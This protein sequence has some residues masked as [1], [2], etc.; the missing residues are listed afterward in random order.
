MKRDKLD[1]LT[2]P[3]AMGDSPALLKAARTIDLIKDLLADLRE[4]CDDLREEMKK[5]ESGDLDQRQRQIAQQRFFEGAPI[6]GAY[7]HGGLEDALNKL[8]KG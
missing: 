4:R 8:M 5:I 7:H 1:K 3:D 6:N 2:R